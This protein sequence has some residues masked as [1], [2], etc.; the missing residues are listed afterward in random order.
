[1]RVEGTGWHVDMKSTTATDAWRLDPCVEDN[2]PSE[3]VIS[4]NQVSGPPLSLRVTNNKS[5]G[6]EGIGH[7]Y[8]SAA[9][10]NGQKIAI[11][12]VTPASDGAFLYLLTWGSY[13]PWEGAPASSLGGFKTQCPVSVNDSIY[14]CSG[15]IDDPNWTGVFKFYR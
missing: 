8:M 1:M 5:P 9:D 3:V 13:P 14:R 12:G 6:C 15:F 4:T 7:V 2:R 11:K 10:V